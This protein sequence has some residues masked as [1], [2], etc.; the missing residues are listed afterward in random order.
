MTAHLVGTPGDTGLVLVEHD[1]RLPTVA[2][3]GV[4]DGATTAQ[5]VVALNPAGASMLPEVS[6]IW[7]GRPG[8]SGHRGSWRRSAQDP[9][10]PD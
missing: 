2:W 9:A 8:L 7:F 4:V 10:H 1:G 6:H 3:L 5:D